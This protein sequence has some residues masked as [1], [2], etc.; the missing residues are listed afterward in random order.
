M[1]GQ[2]TRGMA[3][4]TIQAQQ[5]GS[6]VEVARQVEFWTRPMQ[7]WGPLLTYTV[8]QEGQETRKTPAGKHDGVGN[9]EE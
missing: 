5:G 8:R 2:K 1:A 4:D 7:S 9:M 3:M 6:R